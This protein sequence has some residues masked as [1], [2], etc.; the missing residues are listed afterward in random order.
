M[1]QLVLGT[2][3]M[4]L[5]K[6]LGLRQVPLWSEKLVMPVDWKQKIV[7]LLSFLQKILEE[8]PVNFATTTFVLHC[9]EGR[10]ESV[11][12][13]RCF[14]QNWELQQRQLEMQPH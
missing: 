12:L 6:E 7:V 5:E 14:H 3:Q 8:K 10:S 2:R 1:Q 9:L 11:M 13:L 4:V